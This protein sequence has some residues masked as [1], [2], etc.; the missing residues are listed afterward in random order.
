MRI[1][2]RTFIKRTYD[3]LMTISVQWFV[4]ELAINYFPLR[5]IDEFSNRP[6]H[7]FVVQFMLSRMQV[8]CVL[9]PRRRNRMSKLFCSACV[10]DLHFCDCRNTV[11]LLLFL[12]FRLLLQLLL[13][14]LLTLLL[15]LFSFFPLFTSI[16]SPPCSPNSPPP[17][18]YT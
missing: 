16:Y 10:T 14:V 12:L 4:P 11:V 1:Y 17:T 18:P 13:V 9:P 6:W 3:T 5:H 8:A 15:L 7:L 2:T